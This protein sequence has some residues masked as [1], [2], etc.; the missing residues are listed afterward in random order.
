[1]LHHAPP[2][3]EPTYAIDPGDG[4][5]LR[6]GWTLVWCGWQWDVIRSEAL[7]GLEAPEAVDD[8]GEPLGGQIICRFQPNE[9]SR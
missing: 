1:M 8:G 2:E 5:L 9:F 6:R 3:A 7:M 4:L